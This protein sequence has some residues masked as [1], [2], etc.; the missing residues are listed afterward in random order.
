MISLPVES[1]YFVHDQQG[2]K[3]MAFIPRYRTDSGMRRPWKADCSLESLEKDRGG[4][5]QPV[6]ATAV[7]RN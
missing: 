3:A 6:A 2:A 1:K 4:Y 7:E 5:P